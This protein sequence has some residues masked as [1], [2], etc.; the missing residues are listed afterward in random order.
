MNVYIYGGSRLNANIS[1]VPNNTQVKLNQE[2]SISYKSGIFIVAF[3][4]QDYETD[5]E[6]TYRIGVANNLKK[7]SSLKKELDQ[8]DQADQIEPIYS[9]NFE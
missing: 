9:D 1:I 3:P 4:N 2:Y 8:M 5:F 7:I 6:F